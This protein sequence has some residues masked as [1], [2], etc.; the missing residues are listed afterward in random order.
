MF[1][2]IVWKGNGENKNM[3]VKVRVMYV[4][5]WWFGELRYIN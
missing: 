3:K 5:D 2:Y 4:G 1:K